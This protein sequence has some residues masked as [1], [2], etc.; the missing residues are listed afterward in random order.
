[1]LDELIAD[2][3]VEIM[4][5]A[6][7]LDPKA[8]SKL[9]EVRISCNAALADHSSIQVHDETGINPAVGILGILN[10]LTG[11]QV[12]KG[13]PGW[14]RVQAVFEDDGLIKTFQRTKD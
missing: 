8:I 5:D 3:I 14:G 1:M 11:T 13:T 7:K 9:V 10:G 6:L 4:N 12:Y 2:R